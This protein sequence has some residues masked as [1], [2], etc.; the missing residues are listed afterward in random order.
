MG[1]KAID[2]E[3]L[4]YLSAAADAG[5]FG[6]AAKVLG[7]QT[8]TVSRSVAR[9]EDALGVTMFERGHFGIRLTAAGKGVMVHVRRALA[10]LDAVRSAGRRNGSGSVG[11]IRLGVRMPPIG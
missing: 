4:R 6:R 8:S 2:F 9:T 5:N 7:V 10:D 11:Q 1:G 3:S